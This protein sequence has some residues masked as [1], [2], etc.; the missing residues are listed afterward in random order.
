MGKIVQEMAEMFLWYVS[1]A[2]LP[3]M[4]FLTE[5]TIQATRKVAT[6]HENNQGPMY[7]DGYQYYWM[8]EYARLRHG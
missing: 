5:E 3:F 1:A 7:P 2:L 6:T 4:K 8:P